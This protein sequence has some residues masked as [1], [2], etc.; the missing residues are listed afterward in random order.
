MKNVKRVEVNEV[1]TGQLNVYR[2]T[3]SLTVWT[4]TRT[5][6]QECQGDTFIYFQV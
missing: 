5:L 2:V 4:G 1:Q 6:F 3:E